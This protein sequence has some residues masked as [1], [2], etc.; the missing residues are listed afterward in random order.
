MQIKTVIRFSETQQ[1]D[2]LEFIKKTWKNTYTAF[3]FVYS[4]TEDLY[5]K[6]YTKEISQAKVIG[7][8]F[9]NNNPC[10]YFWSSRFINIFH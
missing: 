9:N 5:T 6:L 1:K 3:P 4:F 2:A 10:G 7:I 8:I